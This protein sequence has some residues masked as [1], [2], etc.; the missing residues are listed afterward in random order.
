MP[1]SDDEDGSDD[2]MM[3]I[4]NKLNYT[5]AHVNLILGHSLAK[6]YQDTLRSPIPER[7]QSLLDQLKARQASD[8]E[9]RN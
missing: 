7:L 8:D 2:D 3:N 6:M 4:P 9:Y 5:Q 1:L